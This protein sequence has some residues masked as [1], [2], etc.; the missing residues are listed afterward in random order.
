MQSEHNEL[1]A[2]AR[3]K[4]LIVLNCG[5]A[6]AV[7]GV[8][9]TSSVIGQAGQAR[10]RGNYT[11]I[12]ANMQGGNSSA[13]FILDAANQEMVAVRW[14]DSRRSLEG[15]GYRNLTEDAK[16]QAPTTR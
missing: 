2:H 10:G 8:A 6:V 13:I 15:I 14:N 7:A 9:T 11:A 16:S 12:S 1:R 3:H 5:L 4:L